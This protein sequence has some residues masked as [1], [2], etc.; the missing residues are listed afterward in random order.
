MP[1]RLSPLASPAG[2]Q[3]D[4]G[5]GVYVHWPFCLSKCPYCDFNSHVATAPLDQAAWR[6]GLLR[7]LE[8]QARTLPPRQRRLTSVFF[9]GGTP[10]LMDP[11]TVGAVI[12]KALSL[13]PVADDLEITLEANPGT[14]ERQ[15]FA[16]FR[17]AGVTRLSLGVQ[18]LDDEALR[19]LGRRH[20]AA[21]ALAALETARALFE[22]FSFDLIYARPGQ[23]LDAWE[24][25]LARA[26]A[27]GPSHLSV[28][29]LTIE[30]G[31]RFFAEHARGAFV[32]P[33]EDLGAALFE[34]TRQRLTEAG[35]PA[36]E[37]S[38]HARPGEES[39]HN[40]IYWRGGE[41][42][43]VGPGAHGRLTSAADEGAFQ[44]TVA[45]RAPEVWL[46]HVSQHGHG[47]KSATVIDRRQRAEEMVMMGLRLEEGL[48]EERLRRLTGLGFAEVLDA[49]GL[50]MASEEGLLHRRAPGVLRATGAGMAVLNALTPALLAYDPSR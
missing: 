31:T 14:V 28:Y 3:G 23:T 49:D 20:D 42:L 34:L 21:G 39:R 24:D 46:R 4:E 32:L 38:N 19:F 8:T 26:V 30:A 13:W 45:H 25:E 15:R 47:L 11:A 35:L 17:Q 7:D 29:Q 40:L 37:V 5:F 1:G 27:L 43:G 22:R 44:A 48:V 6:Q 36:Y 16:D 2:A 12:D 18:S 10:S 41:Y 50:A 33:D 9:G